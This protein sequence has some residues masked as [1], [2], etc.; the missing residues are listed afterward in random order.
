VRVRDLTAEV[1]TARRRSRIEGDP[2]L[3]G[4]RQ[5]YTAGSRPSSAERRRPTPPPARP[6]QRFDP[7]EYIKKKQVKGARGGV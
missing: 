4:K 1:D 5:I 2:R 6:F 7:T 3:E